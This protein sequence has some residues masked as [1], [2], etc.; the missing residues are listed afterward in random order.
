MVKPPPHIDWLVDTKQTV[1][2]ACGKSVAI[3]ELK[4]H[5]N[6]AVL[7]AWAKHFRNH[8]CLDTLIDQLRGAKSRK[9]YLETIKFP[10]KSS[11]LGPP[12]RAG[13]FAEILVC[14]YLEWMLGC[15]V[16]RVRWGNKPTRDESTKGCDVIGFQFS[17]TGQFSPK[18]TLAIFE[19]KAGLSSSSDNRL[20]DAVNDSA[21][22]HFRID[23]SLNF[24][25][26]KLIELGKTAEATSVE[27][28]QNPVDSPYQEQYGAVALVSAF[29]QQAIEATDAKKIPASK[30]SKAVKPHPHHATLMMLV[31]KGNDMMDLVHDLYRRAAH[32]A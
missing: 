14:D 15:W 2:T 4:H 31:I 9:D 29:D 23:E 1:M 10:S 11:K 21:K 22:D 20:Q 3:W 17:K 30:S 28:F 5:D 8:Y 27:R 24:V 25:R 6:E 7:S 16:P 19:T 18:D 12:T 26:Q 13:D 32:E